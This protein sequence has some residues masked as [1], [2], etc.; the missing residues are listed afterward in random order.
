MIRSRL[1]SV[2]HPF[3][4][5]RLAK[6]ALRGIRSDV[7]LPFDMFDEA[8]SAEEAR[9]AKKLES[10]YHKGHRKGWDG[11]TLLPELIAKHGGIHLSPE[12]T[13]AMQGLMG[14]I[15]W[16]ELAAW[17][18]SADLALH[19]E[20]LE[21]KL[22]ATSQAMDEARHFYV[23]HDYLSEI[24]EVPKALGPAAT[25]ILSNTLRAPALPQR[26]LGMQLMIEPLAL[27]IFQAVRETNIEP[28]LT[29]LLTYYERDEARHVALGVLHL[30]RLIRGMSLDE[31][32]SFWAWQLKETWSQF[33]LLKEQAPHLAAVGIDPH[34]I[35]ELARK[36]QVLAIRMMMTELGYDLPVHTALIRAS[37]MRIEWDFPRDGETSRRVR[38]R[39][40]LDA[41]WEDID[42]S[43]TRLSEVAAA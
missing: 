7:A 40:A 3:E 36:K 5:R 1:R 9:A 28:V 22:A 10:I 43:R 21:A 17:K 18:V 38:I 8:R 4:A 15:L 23:M 26:L 31:A 6:E 13:R 24:G 2:F 33:D 27:T 34:R 32:I 37:N 20:P 35:I 11:K 12:K 29:E 16:G 25:R 19:I 14:L 42:T 30:P 39:R 41:I